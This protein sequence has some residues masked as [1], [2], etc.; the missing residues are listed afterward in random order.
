MSEMTLNL[1]RDALNTMLTSLDKGDNYEMSDDMLVNVPITRRNIVTL[2]EK[3]DY[4]AN[5]GHSFCCLQKRD[6]VHQKYPLTTINIMNLQAVEDIYDSSYVNDIIATTGSL[7]LQT[8]CG[9]P[10]N[11]VLL[12]DD[13]YY[14]DRE[15]GAVKPLGEFS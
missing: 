3:L 15:A 11:I 13:E 10:C 6:T 8:A 5:G 12:E 14:T 7:W 2:I 9:Q 1:T 4:V